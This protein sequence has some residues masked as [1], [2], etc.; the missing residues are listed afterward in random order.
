MTPHDFRTSQQGKPPRFGL[1]TST[2]LL[3]EIIKGSFR[4][5][6][7]PKMNPIITSVPITDNAAVT[8]RHTRKSFWMRKV[9]NFEP[10]NSVSCSGMSSRCLLK[11]TKERSR[12]ESQGHPRGWPRIADKPEWFRRKLATAI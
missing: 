8:Y 4:V 6:S 2:C 12:S 10:S 1:E 7:T 9:S 3:I 11:F 5:R